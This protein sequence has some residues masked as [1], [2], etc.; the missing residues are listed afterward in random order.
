[1]LIIFARTERH[2][3]AINL[4]QLKTFSEN[5][6]PIRVWLWLVYKFNDNNCRLRLFSE[7]IQTQ[8]KVSYLPWQNKYANL[9]TTFVVV[10]SSQN[11]PCEL[12]SQRTYFLQNI[13]RL[14]LRLQSYQFLN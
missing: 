4:D 7:F 1:M 9:K 3:S 13:S 5:Y 11:F 12:N 14:S 6:K 8:K 10:V 2:K